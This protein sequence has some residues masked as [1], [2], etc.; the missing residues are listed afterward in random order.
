MRAGGLRI[1]ACLLALVVIGGTVIA[2]PAGA[3]R[4]SQPGSLDSSFGHNGQVFFRAPATLASSSITGMVR[5]PDGDLVLEQRRESTTSSGKRR[6][7]ERRLPDGRPDPSFGKDGRVAVSAGGGLAL[8]PDG[9]ILVGTGSCH[10]TA[11]ILL[12]PHGAKDSNF[13]TN[14]CSASV[15]FRIG[16]IVVQEDGRILLAG[17]A[18]YC[19]PCGHDVQLG[20]ETALAR[21]LPDGSRDPSFG[22]DGVVLTHGEYGLEG[23]VPTGLAPAGDGGLLVS[24]GHMLLRFSASGAPDP[25]FGHGGKVEVGGLAKALVVLPD[26][27]IVLASLS[28]GPSWAEVG[29]FVLSR[30]R[31]D[32]TP[33]TS[34]GD[35]G[36]TAIDI[37]VDDI[38]LALAPT[39]GEGVLLAGESGGGED[40]SVLCQ[41]APVLLR[42]GPSGT[43]DP[44]FGEGD[45]VAELPSPERPESGPHQGLA[46]L[47]SAPGGEA[48]LAG[49]PGSGGDAYVIARGSSGAPS[50]SFGEGG[51]LV[52]R[53]RLPSNTEAT[54][55]AVEP[56]GGI[57]VAAEGNPG[58]HEWGGFLLGF[59]RDG[60]PDRGPGSLGGVVPT[61]A[62]G[63]IQ[64]G[65]S[66]RLVA[67]EDEGHYLLRVGKGGRV[68]R[69][70]GTNGEA[71]LPTGFRAR[72]FLAGADGAV[73][74]V[75]R[76]HGRPGMAV[77]RANAR[78][79]PDARF[80]KDGLAVASF[81]PKVGAEGRAALLE[82]GGRV[83]V[84]G[85]AGASAAAARL[86]PDGRLDPSFGHAG[87][88]RHLL[89]YASVGTQV[90]ALGNGVVIACTSEE[91]SG[92]KLAGIVRLDRFGRRVRAFGRGG[93]VP[94]GAAPPPLSLLSTGRRIVLVSDYPRR[95]LGGVLLR[96]YRSDGSL[97]RGFG[98]RGRA[99]GGVDQRKI[100]QPVAAARQPDGKIVVVG[101]AGAWFAGNQTELLRFR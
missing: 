30:F 65:G 5:Q 93:A 44:T 69:S 34:F 70:Y 79:R 96:A 72:S 26:G 43:L 36:T 31:S 6:E 20:S 87:R 63:Q 61:L 97:D 7:I 2:P 64:P 101:T 53:H 47:V 39:P 71:R 90:A 32:G 51:V 77:Y 15:G 22:K 86:L 81:G 17:S 78:G 33:D 8:R 94:P 58:V 50:K 35:A 23:A 76:V 10:G 46:A 95:R 21:L 49:G 100:F 25:G 52:E 57:A 75:G 91:T 85:W 11:V 40:C 3:S 27:R 99:R 88:S 19:P 48:F 84:T 55:L 41:F 37:G 82:P 80:G 74:V 54:G 28:P 56:N 29:D 98:H 24:A 9:G 92:R 4:G 66:G 1:L 83:V 59:R 68:D 89:G 67:W 16:L 42:I 18:Y 45:G 12:G 14:G 62:R 38:P 73:T 13:G 60:R